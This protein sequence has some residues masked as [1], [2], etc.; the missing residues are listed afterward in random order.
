MPGLSQL[1]E[2]ARRALMSQQVGIGVTS[3]NIANASTP[4]YSP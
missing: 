2:T 1:L 4:G 3:H